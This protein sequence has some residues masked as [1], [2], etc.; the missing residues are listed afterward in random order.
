MVAALLED[1]L[2]R[3]AASPSTRDIV[4][5]R[6]RLVVAEATT[7]LDS[8]PAEDRP[9]VIYLDPMFPARNKAALVK[10]EMQLLQA[11]IGPEPDAEALLDT[12]RRTARRRV[13]V[14][15]PVHAPPLAPGPD[16]VHGGKTMRF[17]VYLGR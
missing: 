1:G 5:A 17:D 15:R 8:L 16:L 9:D 10:K 2:R 4:P 12:A 11:L 6:L 3:A 13:V 14:K 7:W